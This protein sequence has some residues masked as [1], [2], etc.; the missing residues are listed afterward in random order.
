MSVLLS[1]F[2]RCDRKTE[3]RGRF[4]ELGLIHLSQGSAHH[5]SAPLP[6]PGWPGALG[7]TRYVERLAR[8]WQRDNVVDAQVEGS[9]VPAAPPQAPPQSFPRWD[10]R[11]AWFRVRGIACSSPRVKLSSASCDLGVPGL[12]LICSLAG[13]GEGCGETSQPSGG[14]PETLPTLK[15][16]LSRPAPAGPPPSLPLQ[17]QSRKWGNARTN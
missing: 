11:L 3:S 16:G 17:G 6:L 8:C 15:K 12:L 5:P 7:S 1:P 2:L 13:T 14:L 10:E 9:A 4:T